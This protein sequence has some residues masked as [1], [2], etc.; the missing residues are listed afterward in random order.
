MIPEVRKGGKA[1]YLPADVRVSAYEPKKKRRKCQ[2]G[3]PGEWLWQKRTK[4]HWT[5]GDVVCSRCLLYVKLEDQRE[6]IDDFLRK[7]VVTASGDASRT[8]KLVET[9]NMEEDPP[10]LTDQGCWNLAHVVVIT[11]K[12]GVKNLPRRWG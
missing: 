8:A 11:S 4:R 12:A 5:P 6:K 7:L 2:C 1:I 3:C 9:V 10:T